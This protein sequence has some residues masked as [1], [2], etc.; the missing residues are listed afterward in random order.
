GLACDDLAAHIYPCGNAGVPE[1][2]MLTHRE[3]MSNVLATS[4]RLPLL[5]SDVNLSFLPLS[6]I[7]QRHVDY[8]S[9]YAGSTIAYAESIGSVVEDMAAVRPTF[10]AGVPRFFEKMYARVFSQISRGPAIR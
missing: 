7:F 8:A 5:P 10:A 2:A 6:H 3:L 9:F 4:Q 1:G